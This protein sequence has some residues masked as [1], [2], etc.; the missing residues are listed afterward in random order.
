MLFTRSI[1]RKLLF[2]LALILVMLTISSVAGLSGVS[3]YRK[4]MDEL[5]FSVDRAPHASTLT[6]AI[7]EIQEPLG[8]TP[9][10][11]LGQQQQITELVGLDGRIAKAR[12]AV[13]GFRRKI[14][15]VDQFRRDASGM[16]LRPEMDSFV[17]E[18]LETL[19]RGLDEFERQVRLEEAAQRRRPGASRATDDD[20]VVPLPVARL[21]A[22]LNA[23]HDT[24]ER[25]P[26]LALRPQK[27]RSN[28]AYRTQRNLVWATIAVSLALCFGLVQCGY[29]W[30]F[31]PVSKLYEGAR[32]VAQGDLEYRVELNSRDEMAELADAFNQMTAR[33]QEIAADLDRQV[34][35][36]SKQ[37]VRSE[38]LA[39]VGFL[40]AGV[41]HE[42]NNPL[43]A[44]TMATE[45]LQSRLTEMLESAPPADTD[46]FRQYLDMIQSESQRCREIVAKL[47]DFSRGQESVRASCDMTAIVSDVLGM[48]SHLSKYRDRKVSFDATR[49]CRVEVNESEIKQV[50]LNLVANALDSLDSGGE[51]TIEI[52]ERTDHVVVCFIDDGC[53]MSPEVS[54]NLFEPF[55]TTKQPRKGTG[56]GLSISNRIVND[57]GGTLEA[58]SDGPGTG[59]TFRVRLPR[60]GAQPGVAA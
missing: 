36:R 18:R 35:D 7:V 42:I 15:A 34:Q 44:V 50:V 49:P 19:D 21:Y 25:I 57:H 37:L 54:Q 46:V 14:K 29:R 52:L 12:K 39:G 45:S 41:A 17:R 40:A 28:Q 27:T 10:T 56:L 20:K 47:L 8:W 3:T 58:F 38:R 30:I 26:D 16:G 59:S 9:A 51:L 33:F 4:S 60:Q 23:L 43:A 22:Q 32:R 6:A 24:I 31:V 13:N 11:R 5:E 2:G 48:V 1:R 55:F 53:G